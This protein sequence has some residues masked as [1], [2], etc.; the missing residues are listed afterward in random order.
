MAKHWETNQ[1]AGVDWKMLRE[2]GARHPSSPELTGS[3]R[4]KRGDAY[5]C[6]ADRGGA[7]AAEQHR[8][9]ESEGCHK[10]EKKCQVP[11]NFPANTHLPLDEKKRS[12]IGSEGWDTNRDQAVTVRG[13]G[14]FPT[15]KS[16]HGFV[17]REGFLKRPVRV[18]MCP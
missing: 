1:R 12:T 7:V 2:Q 17:G 6:R 11:G 8:G 18:N 13:S 14:R 15:A 3:T 10:G 16:S 5:K 9:K 4:E